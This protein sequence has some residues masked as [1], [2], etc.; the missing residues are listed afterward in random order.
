METTQLQPPDRSAFM[1]AERPDR[2]RAPL[3]GLAAALGTLAEAL[4][5]IL[6]LVETVIG[7]AVHLPRPVDRH[8]R[9]ARA[10]VDFLASLLGHVRAGLSYVLLGAMYLVGV[11]P[12]EGMRAI[13]PYLGVLLL[14]AAFPW[15]SVGFL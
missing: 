6:I 11:D 13:W 14:V 5:A 12:D 4:T 10:M 2:R 7:A 15:L 3:A 1:P 8:D 9:D